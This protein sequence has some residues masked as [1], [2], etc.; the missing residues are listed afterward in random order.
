MERRDS[1]SVMIQEP[2]PEKSRQ[3]A[4]GENNETEIK[5]M[6]RKRERQFRRVPEGFSRFVMAPEEKAGQEVQ[7]Y[8]VLRTVAERNC[9]G[10]NGTRKTGNILGVRRSLSGEII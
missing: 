9:P 2:E 7:K 6:E 5:E 3:T 10:W 8:A 4:R 1:P